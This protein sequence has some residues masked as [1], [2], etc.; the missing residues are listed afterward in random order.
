MKIEHLKFMVLHILQDKPLSGYFLMK[1]IHKRTLWKP[2]TGS[3]YPL[4]IKLHKQE[5]L[6]VKKHKRSKIYF[7]TN[8]GKDE[9][10]QL[11]SKK[12]EFVKNLHTQFEICCSL[13]SKIEKESL[14]KELCKKLKQQE[15]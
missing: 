11:C 9:L 2:S 7:L 1:E 3:I 10:V 15:N 6:K 8:R 12:Q 14:I 5:L 4:L 13:L